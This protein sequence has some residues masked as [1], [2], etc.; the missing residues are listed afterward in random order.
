MYAFRPV[1]WLFVG[2]FVR[3]CVGLNTSIGGAIV[4]YLPHIAM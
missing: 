2:L 3:V 4:V 1:V